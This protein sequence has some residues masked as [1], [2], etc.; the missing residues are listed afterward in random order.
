MNESQQI[1]IVSL[2]TMIAG[3]IGLC[4]RY[5]Y[6]S[7]CSHVRCCCLEFERDVISENEHDKQTQNKSTLS[8]S[9][10]TV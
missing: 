3:I 10:R 2:A 9:E 6:R 5:S 4:I 8:E 1:M 7:R